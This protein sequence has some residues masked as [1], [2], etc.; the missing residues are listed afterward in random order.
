MLLPLSFIFHITE[1]DSCLSGYRAGSTAFEFARA[2]PSSL[3]L[4]LA[5]RRLE[6]LKQIAKDIS[7]A[8][9]TGVEI[10]PC[11]LDVGRPAE[12]KKF[13]PNLPTRFRN[14]DI[15][16]NNAS[17]S[18]RVD[19]MHRGLIS[20][21]EASYAVRQ[22]GMHL[23]VCCLASIGVAEAPDIAHE[24]LDEMLRVN[25]QGL[26]NMTQAVLEIYKQ[27]SDGGRGDVVMIGSIAG[28]EPYKGGSVYCA[29]KAV[30]RLFRAVPLVCR[31][32]V[33]GLIGFFRRCEASLR[34]CAR[35]SPIP[36]SES[37]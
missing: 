36:G 3:K 11:Q 14:I 7:G 33:L 2:S 28:R 19:R 12:V 5:A 9:G 13:V 31:A 18:V 10:W 6:N 23:Q 17:V 30:G 16:V 32:M 20:I 27:R 4:I 15:L 37:L 1:H 34:P 35:N 22:T 21:I 8:V 26:I 25:V 24:D 29:S